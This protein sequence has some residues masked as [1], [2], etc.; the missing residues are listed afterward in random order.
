M[1]DALF[2]QGVIVS[3]SHNSPS[4]ILEALARPNR[5]EQVSLSSR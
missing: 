2:E 3:D 5:S 1:Q 4:I